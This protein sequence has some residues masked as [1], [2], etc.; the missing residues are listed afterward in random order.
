MLVP[1]FA[2]ILL[3]Q[4]V[5]E[6]VARAVHLPLPGPVLGMAMM[7]LA[8]NISPALRDI[9]TPVAKVLLNYLALMFIP[10][11]V[12]V[13]ANLEVLQANW[14]AL[15]ASIVISTVFAILVGA[16]T[17]VFVAKRTES[18]SDD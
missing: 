3:F 9:I 15:T 7:A 12:G 10:V 14:L 4:L 18:G 13:V 1:A 5:G 17:F 6:V 11:G 16:A 2:I 8:L